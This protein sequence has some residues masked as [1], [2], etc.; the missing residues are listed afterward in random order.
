MNRYL[1]I[2]FSFLIL[3]SGCAKKIPDVHVKKSMTPFEAS[4]SNAAK[5]ASNSLRMLSEINNAQKRKVLTKEQV[6]HEIWQRGKHITGLS[7]RTSVSWSGPL[8]TFMD[9]LVENIDGWK[10]ETRNRHSGMNIFVSVDKK[11]ATYLDI[12]KEVGAQAGSDAD[13]IVDPKNKTITA[14]YSTYSGTE[15]VK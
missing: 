1:I 14:V 15:I 9:T 10:F 6:R 2:G 3:M 13:V 5:G 8:Y 11:N 12:I 4:M 7:T